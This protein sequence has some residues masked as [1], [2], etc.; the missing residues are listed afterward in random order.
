MGQGER[1]VR[2]NAL[3]KKLVSM[4]FIY[5]HIDMKVRGADR[6][7]T[8]TVRD[9]EAGNEIDYYDS[10][11]A[12]KEGLEM[13]EASDREEGI[14]EKDFYEVAEIEKENYTLPLAKFMHTRYT[15]PSNTN[16]NMTAEEVYDSICLCVRANFS[17][18]ARELGFIE[19][20]E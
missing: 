13:F 10:Y 19:V 16:P 20:R 6:M 8:W 12:A 5:I 4:D 15:N 14:Y 1:E 7:K 11:E 9:R 2:G 17:E 18:Y 3:T